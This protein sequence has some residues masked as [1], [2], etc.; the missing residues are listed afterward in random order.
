[1]GLE[2]SGFPSGLHL[3]GLRAGDIEDRQR[4]MQR[5][6][7]KAE[8]VPVRL[9][10]EQQQLVHE[11]QEGRGARCQALQHARRGQGSVRDLQGDH[12]E[13]DPALKDNL[14]RLGIALH[15][16]TTASL[17]A[18]TVMQAPSRVHAAHLTEEP[19]GRY[20]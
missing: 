17:F 7:L 5:R 1:M 12:C 20:R 15:A 10:E 6:V 11:L 18:H 9:R 13:G 2:L 3:E 4:V 8:H 16:H 19:A 14:G